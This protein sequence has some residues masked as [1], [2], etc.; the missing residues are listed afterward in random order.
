M[1]LNEAMAEFGPS[2]LRVWLPL[3]MLGGFLA[4]LALLIWRQTRLTGV[5]T[6]LASLIAAVGIDYMYKQM[7]YVK[8][9]GLP[10]VIVWTPLVAYLILQLRRDGLP[11]WPAR[12]IKFI[13]AILCISLVFDYVDVARYFLGNTL[14]L[15]TYA[16][17]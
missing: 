9:L 10:H 13:I 15:V 6:F 17:A 1:S 4:P 11:V 7:G 3:L 14:P 16:P 8:L 2:W 12:L 5:I